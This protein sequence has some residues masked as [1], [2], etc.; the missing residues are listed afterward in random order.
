MTEGS[1]AGFSARGLRFGNQGAGSAPDFA[2]NDR[3]EADDHWA[4]PVGQ[5]CGKCAAEL[6]TRDF[7]RR[8]LDGSWVHEACPGG[9]SAQDDVDPDAAE[10][11]PNS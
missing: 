9:V 7:I 10:P 11:A 1:D 5:T 3:G 2:R 6:T 4:R 8:R